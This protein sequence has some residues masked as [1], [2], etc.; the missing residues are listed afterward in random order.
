MEAKVCSG[1]RIEKPLSEFNKKGKGRLQSKCREC[2]KAYL[3]KH[4]REHKSYYAKK[5]E[6]YRAL[7][8][9][10]WE[11]YKAT[12]QCTVCGESHSACIEFH[13]EDPAKKEHNVSVMLRQLASWER[14]MAEVEKCTV[15]CANCHRKVHY[16]QRRE[17][18]VSGT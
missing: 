13:H 15:L 5:R 7:F 6:K 11:E 16:E 8:Q 17:Q 12:L 10:R 3:R 2:N 9:K 1:C 4:Y 14:I 18:C